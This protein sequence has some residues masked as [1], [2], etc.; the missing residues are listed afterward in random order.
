MGSGRPPVEK[1]NLHLKIGHFWIF[2]FWKSF[3]LYFNTHLYFDLYFESCR[4]CGSL[5][6][7]PSVGVSSNDGNCREPFRRSSMTRI[8]TI[9][10]WSYLQSPCL[11]IGD[12]TD[13]YPSRCTDTH[14]HSTRLNPITDSWTCKGYQC[15]ISLHNCSYNS[16][17]YKV[18]TATHTSIKM[19]DIPLT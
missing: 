11:Q 16:H 17:G 4:F 2:E 8:L 15:H 12:S 5:Y 19:L 3:W 14:P 1:I 6:Q 10:W 7:Q 9:Y 18:V 13:K